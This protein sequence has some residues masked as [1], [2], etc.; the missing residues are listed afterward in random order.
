MYVLAISRSYI[1]RLSRQGI[2]ILERRNFSTATTDRAWA[3]VDWLTVLI[4]DHVSNMMFTPGLPTAG[5][6]ESDPKLVAGMIRQALP[7]G[8][9]GFQTVSRA[10]PTLI[11]PDCA[12]RRFR[13]VF[14]RKAFRIVGRYPIKLFQRLCVHS[15]V[16]PAIGEILVR[17]YVGRAIFDELLEFF[18]GHCIFMGVV[19]I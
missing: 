4:D 6:T 12:R 11:P 3:F 8:I 14:V 16:V 9:V 19:Q 10:N 17:V 18:A 2:A 1:E 13:T 5:L 7:S 15:L